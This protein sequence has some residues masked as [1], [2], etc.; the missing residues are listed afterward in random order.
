[1]TRHGI[2]VANTAFCHLFSCWSFH[3]LLL[4][5]IHSHFH[6]F[7]IFLS[8][9]SSVCLFML[10]FIL[11]SIRSFIYLASS[12]EASNRELEGQSCFGPSA[13]KSDL[14]CTQ[15]W[16][17]LWAFQFSVS[18]KIA[19]LKASEGALD[20]EW[21]AALGDGM[22]WV[23]ELASSKEAWDSFS[24]RQNYDGAS[25]PHIKSNSFSH[26]K[27]DS[28]SCYRSTF[29]SQTTHDLEP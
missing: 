27:I 26:I 17:I 12:V 29:E 22:A 21:E 2:K 23:P 7:P 9:P 18:L 14:A 24:D 8:I 19:S 13:H 11:A 25:F 5:F 4:L 1:M 6:S 16:A 15:K 20:R 3:L 28:F 10:S